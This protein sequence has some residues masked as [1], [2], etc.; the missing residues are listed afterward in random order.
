MLDIV[1]KYCLLAD[2]KMNISTTAASSEQFGIFLW[3]LLMLLISN[4]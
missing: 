1:S 3:L 2:W 4:R